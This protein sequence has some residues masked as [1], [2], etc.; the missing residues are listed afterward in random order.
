ML[1]FQN[2]KNG[3]N[4]GQEATPETLIYLFTQQC[5]RLVDPTWLEGLKRLVFQ[6]YDLSI[7]AGVS[8]FENRHHWGQEATPEAF[9]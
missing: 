4:W 7:G 3:H 6:S 8:K 2:S 1:A 5:S 9:I